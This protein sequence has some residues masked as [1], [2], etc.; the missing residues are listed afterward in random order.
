MKLNSDS[1]R[2]ITTSKGEPIKF[3]LPE[4]N[5]RWNQ[6]SEYDLREYADVCLYV[7]VA[8][9]NKETLR[10][11]ILCHYNGSIQTSALKLIG[12]TLEK[13]RKANSLIK[14]FLRNESKIISGFKMK[15]LYCEVILI[16]ESQSDRL[17]TYERI[18]RECRDP[19]IGL[20]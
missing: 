12:S 6:D 20:Q 16:D 15:N 7:G 19:L 14:E 5:P 1:N 18:L 17:Y 4:I 13:G 2:G 3:L 10:E 11:R 9:G 8:K